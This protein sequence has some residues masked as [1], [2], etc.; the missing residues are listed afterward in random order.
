MVTLN[1]IR[2]V[3]CMSERYAHESTFSCAC[4]KDMHTKVPFLVHEKSDLK[5]FEVSRMPQKV[6]EGII[7]III[8][9]FDFMFGQQTNSDK[10]IQIFRGSVAMNS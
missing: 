5:L 8:F 4:Q 2:T 6:K 3:L 10:L 7:Q 1:F 9:F